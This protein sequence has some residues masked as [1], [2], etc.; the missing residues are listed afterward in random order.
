MDYACTKRLLDIT[1]STAALLLLSPVLL[2]TAIAIRAESEGSPFFF[3]QRIGQGLK[4]FGIVKFRSMVKNA[5]SLGSWQTQDA[6]PR[7][8]RVGRFIRKTSLDELPQ[9][10]NVLKGDMSL[11][12]PRPNTPQQE[13][14]YTTEQWVARHAIRP[15][16]T[17]L[18][19]VSGRSSLSVDQQIACD[20]QYNTSL[21]LKQDLRIILKT[22]RLA[23]A[24]S[25]VN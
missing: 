21:S 14:Q 19:Q 25:G 20:L 7:I 2:A 15:G 12:G 5:P 11:V 4:P 6:D 1:A 3:Q 9:L 22:L 24:R 23:L 16:I 8:T 17:G 13:S 18:A 10:W